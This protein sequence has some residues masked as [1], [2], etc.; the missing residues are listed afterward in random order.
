MNKKKTFAVILFL[1]MAV[2]SFTFAN[3]SPELKRTEDSSNEQE[4]NKVDKDSNDD[5]SSNTK[6]S[7]SNSYLV[8]KKAVEKAEYSL[9][10]EDLNNALKLVK[11]LSNG[12]NKDALSDRLNEVQKTIDAIALVENLEEKIANVSSIDDV[13]GARDYRSSEAI[14]ELVNSLT[15]QSVKDDLLKRLD[16]LSPIL[17]DEEAPVIEGVS[18]NAITNQ[19]VN[20]TVTDAGTVKVKLNGIDATLDDLIAISDE[21]EYVVVVTDEA[22]NEQTLTFTIDTTAPVINFADGSHINYN[23]TPIVADEHL[24]AATLSKN[25]G[26]EVFYPIID[27]VGLELTG[28][29]KF[30]LTVTDLAGNKTTKTLII[31]KTAPTILIDNTSME[32]E[33][34]DSDSF[35]APTYN[36]TD[37][38]TSD[39][40]VEVTDCDVNRALVGTYSCEYQ[41]TDLA[42][43][44]ASAS[45]SVVVKDTVAPVINGI[46]EASYVYDGIGVTPT[47]DD[48]D[49]KTVVLTKNGEVVT[50]YTLGTAIVD[51]G[52]YVLSVTDN[53]GLV[54]VKDFEI[55]K[56]DVTIEWTKPELVYDGSAK[57]FIATV[58]RGDVVLEVVEVKYVDILHDIVLGSAPIDAGK[59]QVS[60]YYAG[61]NNHNAKAD[62][63]EVV[64]EMVIDSDEDLAYAIKKQYDGQT[65]TIKEGTYN[66]YRGT[67]MYGL[68]GSET[69]G[70]Y[71]PLVADNLTIKGEDGVKIIAGEQATNAEHSSQN[72]VTIFGDN[73]TIDNVTL[74]AQIDPSTSLP[75]KVIEI[76]GDNATLNNVNIDKDELDFAGSIYV[77]AKGIKTTLNNVKLNK[78]RIDLTGADSTNTLIL[79]NVVADFANAIYELDSY[80]F[81]NPNKANVIANNFTVT[82]S[83]ALASKMSEFINQ[84]PANTKVVLE[85][86][87]YNLGHLEVANNIILEGSSNNTILNVDSDPISNQAGVYV[88]TSATIKNLKIVANTSKVAKL[89]ALKVSANSDSTIS[90]ATIAD[91]VIVG[92]YHGINIHGVEDATINNVNISGTD[93]LAISVASSDV[94]LTNSTLV[95]GSFGYAMGI[96][97]NPSDLVSYPC[98]SNVYVGTGNTI[99]D[100]I[101]AEYYEEG[102]V[103]TFADSSKW[104]EVIN[105]TN[106]EYIPNN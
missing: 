89:N 95:A 23:M 30:V 38:Y 81:S 54:T 39:V 93:A 3:P 78:G 90:H 57:E 97:Y 28:E 71:L 12:K 64:I 43:N 73:V 18:D 62:S 19:V 105:G 31:D 11:K 66:V 14:V 104:T 56:A 6:V 42:G 20:L 99:N 35:I 80:G 15:N 76:F 82:V 16:A 79:N 55:T 85:D 65:W 10:L 8:A 87:N 103:Y 77:N 84:L 46:D 25:D 40:I 33:R 1:I 5:E 36:A 91:V 63:F 44:K 21:G 22:F 17:D 52:T 70:W 37:N 83:S 24:D 27:G 72:F 53:N 75:D 34:S 4:E 2:F 32:V 41:A 26:E 92:G 48:L 59:Y 94:K 74:V 7:T 98:V 86:G 67:D 49:I 88:K 58:K 45:I 69:S 13:N 29:G 61:D 100:G 50:G 96:M 101:Y 9:S 47:S 60:A 106:K 68:E 51:A 102:N